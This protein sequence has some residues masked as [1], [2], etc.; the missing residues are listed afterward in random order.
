MQTL[1]QTNGRRW[2]SHRG[3]AAGLDR[4]DEKANQRPEPLAWG[5]LLGLGLPPAG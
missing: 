5:W 2:G 4:V 3:E 1:C